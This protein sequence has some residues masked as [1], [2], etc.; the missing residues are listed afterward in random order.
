MDVD[1]LP[2]VHK[3]LVSSI[4]KK[5][6]KL[7]TIRIFCFDNE[8]I[9]VITIAFMFHSIVQLLFFGYQNLTLYLTPTLCA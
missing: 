3:S 2:V 1:V 5:V 9:L 6:V 8:G 7:K 4:K